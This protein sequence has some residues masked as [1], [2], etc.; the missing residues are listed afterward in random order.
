MIG[1]ANK[2]TDRQTNRDYI[3]TEIYSLINLFSLFLERKNLCS[4]VTTMKK[5][6]KRNLIIISMYRAIFDECVRKYIIHLRTNEY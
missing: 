4:L 2:Q 6:E 3:F 5:L 1:K